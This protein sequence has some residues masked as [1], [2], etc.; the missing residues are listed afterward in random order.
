M[1]ETVAVYIRVAITIMMFASL[2]VT[3]LNI[4][5]IA[6]R[7]FYHLRENMVG[8][9]NS[10]IY[11]E[12]SELVYQDRLSAPEAYKY[13][14]AHPEMEIGMPLDPVSGSPIGVDSLISVYAAGYVKF[15][16]CAHAG[17]HVYDLTFV[18]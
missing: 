12:G 7:T 17:A 8:R 9:V 4:T 2:M 15:T 13:C 10:A 16:D 14:E 11:N 5:V 1:S 18:D 6:S 3:V